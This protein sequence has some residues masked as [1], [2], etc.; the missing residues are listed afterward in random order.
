MTKPSRGRKQAR[1]WV[2]FCGYALALTAEQEFVMRTPETV[3]CTEAGSDLQIS[4][5]EATRTVSLRIVEVSRFPSLIASKMAEVTLDLIELEALR[6]TIAG[7]LQR[8][9]T[10]SE[11]AEERRRYVVSRIAEALD[12]FP[13]GPSQTGP[14]HVVKEHLL[15]A[16]TVLLDL[17]RP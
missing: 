15:K 10:P 12:G 2:S 7:Y 17:A 1:N 16:G 4:S 9:A 8:P 3:I 14:W 11:T 6:L 13:V 5:D